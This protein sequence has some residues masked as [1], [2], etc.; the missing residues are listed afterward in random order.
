[1]VPLLLICVNMSPSIL[2][3]MVEFVGILHHGH[4][5]LFQVQELG[6]LP[7]QHTSRNVVLSK[8]SGKLL[9]SH[10][11]IYRLHGIES[12]PPCTGRSQKLLCDKAHILLVGHHEQ[13]KLLL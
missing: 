10:R 2:C 13:Q 7:V 9:P 12:I 8:G 1:M 4:T 5:S 11:M 3:N 6:Q